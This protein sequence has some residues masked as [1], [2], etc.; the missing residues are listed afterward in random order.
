MHASDTFA[1]CVGGCVAAAGTKT[2]SETALAA[3]TSRDRQVGD[4]VQRWVNLIAETFCTFDIQTRRETKFRVNALTRS[5]GGFGVARFTTT[6]GRAQLERTAA[7]IR[8]D[9]RDD[10]VLYLPVC[11][12]H[13]LLQRTRRTICSPAC[14]TLISTAEPFV[15]TKFGDNDTLYL[16]M[17]RMFVDQRLVRGEGVCGRLVGTRSGVGRLAAETVA[18]LQREAAQLGGTD[19]VGAARAAADLV[20]L[21]IAG[22]ADLMTQDR[23]IRTSNL[24]RAKRVIRARLGD[25]DLSLSDIADECGISLRYLHDLF[26]DDG[27]TVREYLQGERLQ[28]ARSLLERSAS[29]P[30]SI[31]QICMTCGFATPSQFSTA[32]KRAFGLSPRDVVRRA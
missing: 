31:T 21:G 12:E 24:A 26:R 8:A 11:G 28:A 9:N 10:Y 3:D 25:A 7:V 20:L 15:Q 5:E 22:A 17:P 16:S 6:A 32:F 19:F 1:V 14:M 30:V 2:S 4:H 23:S 18:A 27:R 13:E 29:G